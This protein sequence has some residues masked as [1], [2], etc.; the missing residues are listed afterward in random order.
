MHNFDTED[1]LLFILNMDSSVRDADAAVQSLSRSDVSDRTMEEARPCGLA[2]A[3]GRMAEAHFEALW[4][5]H[6]D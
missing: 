5:G 4:E 6:R 1:G 3:L 2:R